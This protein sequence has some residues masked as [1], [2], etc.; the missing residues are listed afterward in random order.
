M[1]QPLQNRLRAYE[2]YSGITFFRSQLLLLAVALSVSAIQWFLIDRA[3]LPSTLIYSFVAGNVLNVLLSLAVPFFSFAFPQ[4]WIAFLAI[5]LPVSFIASAAGGVIDRLILRIPMA[6]L[7]DLRKGDIPYGALICFVIGV[8]MRVF[9][10]VRARL[11]AANNQLAQQVQYGRQELETQASDL[12]DAFEIQSSLLPRTIPQIAGVEISCA[13]QPARTVSGDYFDVLVLSDSRIAFCLADVSGKGMS[14]ALI[15]AN[16]QA[17]LRA[18]APD[19]SSPARLCHRL[20]QALCASLPTGRFVTLVY[21]ILD[22]KRMTL[23]YELAGHNA[24]LLLRG[25]EV[26]PLPGSGPVLGILPGAVFSDQA[27]ALRPG[28]RILI[29]TDGVTEAFNPTG[30]EFGDDRLVA[31]ALN[32]GDTAH[33]IRAEVMRAVS[34]FAEDHFHDDASLLVVRLDQ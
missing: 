23:T 25:S 11:Q 3:S 21:G 1:F 15:T 13:W 24:P 7:A 16:L 12:R 29:S 34:L 4:D 31:A 8:S 5:L 28:D 33:S 27:F 10:S 18:F 14:A 26:I 32:G 9:A 22:R 30:E 2:R 17:T 6:P 19:E 20:N